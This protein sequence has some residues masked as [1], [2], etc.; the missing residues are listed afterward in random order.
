M[1]PMARAMAVLSLFFLGACNLL[2]A[3]HPDYKA[4][5]Q[6]IT[7]GERQWAASTTSGDVSTVERILA[8]DFVGVDTDGSLYDKAKQMA[9]TRDSPKKYIS[10]RLNAVRV[11]FFGDTGVAQGDESW[12][13]RS[14]TPR[15]GRFVWIDTW[16]LRNGKWQIVAAE[17]VIAPENPS[18]HK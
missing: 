8:D 11:R 4:A 9:Q 10:N 16:V 5:E 2:P 12:E 14:G 15:R 17:D 13:R 1:S 6:Y 3:Q 18:T 7:E